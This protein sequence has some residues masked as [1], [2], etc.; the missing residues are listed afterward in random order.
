MHLIYII[1]YI[2]FSKLF[3]IFKN[4]LFVKKIFV[5]NF[6]DNMINSYVATLKKDGFVIISNRGN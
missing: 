4:F 6:S 1:K 3:Y 2:L 5:K